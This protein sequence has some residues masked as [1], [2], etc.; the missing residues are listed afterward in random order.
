MK[1][2]KRIAVLLTTGFLAFAP[3]GTLIF[4][5]MIILGVVGSV[6]LVAGGTLGVV[7]ISVTWLI[8]RRRTKTDE[9]KMRIK[10]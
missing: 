10:G 5:F 1:S 6:W 4:L 8:I 3:P 2:F 7:L 9:E